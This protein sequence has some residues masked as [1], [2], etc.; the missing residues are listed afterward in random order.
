MAAS[1]QL[2][3][4]IQMMRGEGT[5]EAKTTDDGRLNYE[6]IGVGVSAGR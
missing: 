5:E 4:V 3:K 2:D 6:K 1:P